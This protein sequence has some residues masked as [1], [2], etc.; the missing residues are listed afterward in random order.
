MRISIYDDDLLGDDELDVI[1]KCSEWLFNKLKLASRGCII[2][3]FI[4]DDLD[5]CGYMTVSSDNSYEIELRND[6]ELLT[7]LCHEFV[8]I[9]QFAFKK[10]KHTN[11]IGVIDGNI[12]EYK[13][14]LGKL[15][16]PT[17]A[18]DVYHNSPWEIEA[19]DLET[20][21]VNEFW[22]ISDKQLI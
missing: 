16:E 9:Q 8:H 7:T 13:L 12:F 10:L 18:S 11:S 19:R 22:S 5:C 2:D 6:K 1:S 4:N 15:Y 14:W 21:L 17:N 20:K 3:I